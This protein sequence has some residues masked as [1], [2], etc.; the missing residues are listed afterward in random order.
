MVTFAGTANL[1]GALLECLFQQIEEEEV[2]VEWLGET[3]SVWV[4]SP[5][6]GTLLC[7]LY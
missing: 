4:Q 5:T 3:G 6:G 2:G 1:E 7:K